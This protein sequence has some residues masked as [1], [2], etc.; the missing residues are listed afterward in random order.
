MRNGKLIVSAVLLAGTLYSCGSK[1]KLTPEEQEHA[2]YDLI[3]EEKLSMFGALPEVKDA[4]SAKSKLGYV[5]YYDNRLSKDGTQSCNSCHNL[6]TFGV[7][8]LPTSP[9]DLG[10]HGDRNSPTVLNAALHQTQFWD[11]R[12]KDIEEQAGMPILNPVEMNIP[13]EAFLISRLKG[14]DLYTK[15]FAEAYPMDKDPI[16]YKNLRDAIGAFERELITPSRFDKYV[17]GDKSALTIDEKKGML[18]FIEVGCTTCHAGALL[19]GD[20]FQKFG[21]YQP[22]HKFTASEKLDYGMYALSKDSNQLFMFKV[23][24]LRN[25]AETKPYFHDGSVSDLATAVKIMGHTQLDIEL[26]ETEIYKIVAFLHSLTG[27]ISNPEYK[28]VPAELASK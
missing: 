21:V 27:D 17:K 5:L 11:G 19:G 24:S 18:T 4:G 6:S 13:S 8:L 14:I 25:I 22:Y 28:K 12:A 7:D 20:M 9:G 16:T 2:R 23:P 1:G 26:S 10:K 3:L 15:L